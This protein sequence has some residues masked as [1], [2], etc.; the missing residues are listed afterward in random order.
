MLICVCVQVQEMRMGYEA[1]SILMT[2]F[3][4]C[5]VCKKRFG[6]QRYAL[7][8]YMSLPSPVIE[9]LQNLLHTDQQPVTNLT[10]SIQNS[11]KMDLLSCTFDVGRDCK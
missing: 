10:F 2:E 11:S 8:V 6:N 3:N 4:V 5:P 7:V 1:Q 9:P